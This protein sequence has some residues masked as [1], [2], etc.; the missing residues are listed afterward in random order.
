MESR[1]C[2]I[3]GCGNRPKCQGMCAGHY[4]RVRRYGDPLGGKNPVKPQ[5]S[6]DPSDECVIDGCSNL[7]YAKDMCH[8]HYGRWWKTGDPE[9]PY[10]RLY[11]LAGKPCPVQGCDRVIQSGGLCGGHYDRKRRHGDVLADVPLRVS[12]GRRKN[13]QGY[14]T[15]RR[16]G[17][18]VMEHRV[19]MEEL[20]GRPLYRD[21][22]VHHKNGVRDDNRPE[23]LELWSSLHPVGQ[24]V[25]DKLSWAYEIID[26]YEGIAAA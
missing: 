3:V 12:T 19:V 14:V 23:N 15:V 16:G 17:R 5:N 24:R 4:N 8:R 7:L 13:S 6:P 25:E 2:S 9:T 1:T 20:V 18:S 21:E 22:T 11:G 26:R 10:T